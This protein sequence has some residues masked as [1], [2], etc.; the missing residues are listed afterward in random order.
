[1]FRIYDNN[2]VDFW[3]KEYDFLIL[4]TDILIE[5]DGDYWHGNEDV[6]KDL[7]K[8]QKT[9]RKND[10]IKENFANLEGYS[11]VRFWGKD[12]KKNKD[13]VKNK[14]KKIWEKLN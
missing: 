4:N 11:I 2:K 14:M 5:V 12:I 10:E 6:F 7:S 8:F 9:V 1:M 13:E 3:F